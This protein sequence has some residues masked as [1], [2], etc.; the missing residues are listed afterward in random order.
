MPNA[1][2]AVRVKSGA[3]PVPVI[4]ER[5]EAAAAGTG[6]PPAGL[7]PLDF[8]GAGV[9]VVGVGAGGVVGGASVGTDE[10]VAVGA[11]AEAVG[12]AEPAAGLEAAADGDAAGLGV[13]RGAVGLPPVALAEG[14]GG[15]DGGV[16]ASVCAA[17]FANIVTR[18]NI[19]SRLATP[20]RQVSRESRRSPASRWARKLR[21]FMAA[22]TASVRLRAHQ[23]RA[24]G[25]LPPRCRPGR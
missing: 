2:K 18:A 19:V 7:E 5:L 23:G 6:Y 3:T 14:R 24:S 10:G 22:M 4:A 9:V 8:V 15:G 11:G 1:E 25:L 12:R 17:V 20:V 13:G 16:A 21:C